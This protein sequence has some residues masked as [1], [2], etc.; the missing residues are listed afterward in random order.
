MCVCVCINIYTWVGFKL[1]LGVTLIYITP[2]NIFLLDANF[3]KSAIGLDF[4]FILYMFKFQVFVLK[5]VH[6]KWV[7]IRV[8]YTGGSQVPTTNDKSKSK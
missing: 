8:A 2:L 3:N 4:L 7:S 1:H 6:K 5:I